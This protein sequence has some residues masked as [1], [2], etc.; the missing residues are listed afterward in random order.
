MPRHRLKPL[1]K[2]TN[3]I[4]NRYR[5][6][7]REM[8]KLWLATP[9]ALRIP[10]TQGEFADKFGIHPGTLSDWKDV[11]GFM[12]DVVKTAKRLAR[13]FTPDVIHALRR[14]ATS[15]GPGT[16]PDR[17]LWVQYIEEWIERNENVAQPQTIIFERPKSDAR[18]A[19]PK[20]NPAQTPPG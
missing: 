12:D 15:V 4:R 18:P 20:E 1:P 13:E 2:A 3:P 8:F 6:A 5:H 11:P 19:S 7:E 14:S 17:K 16:S 10:Q 9:S